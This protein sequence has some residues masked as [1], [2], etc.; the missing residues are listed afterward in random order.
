[1]EVVVVASQLV[2]AVQAEEVGQEVVVE[3]VVQLKLEVEV[4]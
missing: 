3:E 4:A 1:V 2:V